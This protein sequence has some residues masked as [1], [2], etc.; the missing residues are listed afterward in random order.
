DSFY[1]IEHCVF[2]MEGL[3]DQA[4]SS[5]NTA[6]FRWTPENWRMHKELSDTSSGMKRTWDIISDQMVNERMLNEQQ[7]I[8]MERRFAKMNDEW[9]LI[10]YVGV[11]Q[12]R[13]H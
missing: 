5:L 9:Y 4:D 3:P 10:Y 8:G 7:G 11:N 2:P 6:G 1:Q 12:Y 13:K